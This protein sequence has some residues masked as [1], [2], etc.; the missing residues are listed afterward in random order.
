[1]QIP[2][3]MLSDVVNKVDTTIYDMVFGEDGEKDKDK[4]KKRGIAGAVFDGL[5]NN[6]NQFKDWIKREM[7]DPIKKFFSKENLSEKATEVMDV[8][9]IENPKDKLKNIIKNFKDSENY[10]RA[11]NEAASPFSYGKSAILK[12]ADELELFKKLNE[13]G[14]SKKAYNNSLKNTK[15]KIIEKLTTPQIAYA[16]GVDHPSISNLNG[17]DI[18]DE[19]SKAKN[20]KGKKGRNNIPGFAKGK[21]VKETGLAVL[22]KGEAVVPFPF[23]DDP[24]NTTK[25]NRAIITKQREK[26]EDKKRNTFL[27]FFKDAGFADMTE[28]D[29]PGF[30]K[31]KKLDKYVDNFLSDPKTFI[32]KY[33]NV[34]SKGKNNIVTKNFDQILDEAK[35]RLS[36][37]NPKEAVIIGKQIEDAL[38]ESNEQEYG[39]EDFA[40]GRDK[41]IFGKSLSTLWQAITKTGSSIIG[42]LNTYNQDS[43]GKEVDPKKE[44]DELMKT[45]T[46]QAKSYF[47]EMIGGSVLGTGISMITGIV[48]GP[49]VG[50]A[51]GAGVS[52]V[53]HS[54][55]VQNALFGKIGEDG[56]REGNL[57]S[58]DVS[59]LGKLTKG[60]GNAAKAVGGAVAGSGVGKAVSESKV[61]VCRKPV[62]CKR[63][64]TKQNSTK[65]GLKCR[66]KCC[67]IQIRAV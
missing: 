25:G 61:T 10:K 53:R 45:V 19:K 57:L 1:L 62:N 2:G 28:S 50:A 31:G 63:K 40:E 52:L 43:K 60:F 38:S 12:K 36:N 22:S 55:K 16:D 21:L 17:I 41:N 24:Y 42:H 13:T 66:K 32:E 39:K 47:P 37:M 44:Q 9:G 4:L 59:N 30:A 18:N 33:A 48:G 20:K 3:K 51:L 34:K 67:S 5:K 58:K 7:L 49:L 23:E 8:L 64:K 6:F 56:E 65:N 27:K 35:I 14:E 29:I 11:L 54:D 15:S 26:E 46:E